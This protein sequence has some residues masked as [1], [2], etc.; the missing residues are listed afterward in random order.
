MKASKRHT[1]IQVG[2]K[3]KQV[4]CSKC[5]ARKRHRECWRSSAADL[6]CGDCARPIDCSYG[7]VSVGSQIENTQEIVKL[8]WLATFVEGWLDG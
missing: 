4:V 5:T 8:R 3:H 1:T 2:R 7:S 6:N